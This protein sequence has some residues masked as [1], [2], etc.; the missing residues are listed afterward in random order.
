MPISVGT[1]CVWLSLLKGWQWQGVAA[2]SIVGTV[3]LWGSF[4]LQNSFLFLFFPLRHIPQIES[5]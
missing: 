3:F 4:C 1:R 2:D 5:E